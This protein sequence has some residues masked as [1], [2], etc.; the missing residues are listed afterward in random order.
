MRVQSLVVLAALCAAGCI[1]H[2]HDRVIVT[3]SDPD[4]TV[5]V[6][7]SAFA[8]QSSYPTDIVI[9]DS[10]GIRDVA[11]VFDGGT[12]QAVR[13]GAGA[14]S[15]PTGIS[16]YSI[17][18]SSVFGD[19]LEIVDAA[20][21]AAVVNNGNAGGTPTSVL[22]VFNPTSGANLQ[23][24]NLARSYTFGGSPQDTQGN[25][26][27]TITQGDCSGVC[28]VPTSG[29]QGKLYVSM[30]NVQQASPTFELLP[31]TAQ[32]FAVDWSNG[33]PVTTTPATTLPTTHYNP[34]QVTRFTDPGSGRN[35]VLVTMS[36][37]YQ[38]GG[39]INTV[40]S[41]DVIDTTTDAIVTNIPLGLAAASFHAIALR[42]AWNASTSTL[43][44]FG[45]LGSSLN[46][47]LYQVN[48]TQIHALNVA[49]SL[50]ASYTGGV[51]NDASSPLAVSGAG[52]YIVDVKAAAGGR[53]VFAS[54]FN[55]GDIRV[56]DFGGATPSLNVSPGP[57]VI[58]D[59]TNFVSAGWM[60][61]RP[62]NFEGPEIFATTGSWPGPDA[63]ASVQ[64][65]LK[66]SAP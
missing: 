33:T 27:T 2:D 45:L 60:A 19:D 7:K 37:K 55:N 31:G 18:T 56:C 15:A 50:P 53:W 64:T 40:S 34:T 5:A 10:P 32:V 48:L 9:A 3:Q 13:C 12:V 62:G 52:D 1:R 36:G 54:S 25:T 23:S 43:E 21:G 47:N 38:F 14:L 8:L 11:F 6:L 20:R 16:G 35:Y 22:E 4:T 58:G 24:L 61:L 49:S 26:V 41:I 66:V 63:V 29:T 65:S 44:T 42:Q 30:S 51:V 28:F 39:T 57:F 46:G 17:Q 59:P